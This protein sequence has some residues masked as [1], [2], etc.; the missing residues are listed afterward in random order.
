MARK[1]LSKRLFR[2]V[3]WV[4]VT[5]V[6]LFLS[7]LLLFRYVNPPTSAFMLGYSFAHPHKEVQQ[8]W[9]SF[10]DISPW[11][12]LAVVASE[13]QRFPDH[14]GVDFVA[15]RKALAEYH[16]GDGLRGASTITQQTAK[17]LF[18]WNG[19]SFVRKT[20]E[21]GLALAVDGLW[22][23]RRILE[24]YLNIAEFGPGIYGVEAAS[25]A[26]F[27]ISARQLSASQSARLAA[28]LP[29]PKVLSVTSPSPYVR[30]RIFWIRGQM[31]QL[32]GLHYLKD[33]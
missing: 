28:I 6:L 11:M 27:G 18:L 9:V 17:N 13:D 32:S 20:L 7:V 19:R 29:N 23:K 3:A 15:I 14:W 21:A 26:Y 33:L 1:S 10:S 5:L 4:L 30:D 25:K 2:S 12:P 31:D 16:A 24:V 8:Q 22:P